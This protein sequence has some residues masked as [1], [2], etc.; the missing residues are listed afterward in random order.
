MD[1]LFYIDSSR[2]LAISYQDFFLSV[3]SETKKFNPHCHESNFEDV[4]RQIVVSLK[5]DIPITVFDCNLSKSEVENLMSSEE[6]LNCDK[7]IS[8]EEIN[9]NT[10]TNFYTHCCNLK[11]WSINL[12]TSGTTAKPRKVSHSF[13]SLNR[14]LRINSNQSEKIWGSA[15]N[16]THIAGLQVFFQAFFNLNLLV[17]FFGLPNQV[18]YN[19]IS[20]HGITNISG[21]STF[22]K[23]LYS[24]DHFFNS[25]SRITF[26]GEKFDSLISKKLIKMFPNAKQLNIYASTECGSLFASKNDEFEISKLMKEF[27]RIENDE[28]LIHKSKL[29]YSSN[30]QVVNDWYRTGDIVEITSNNPLRFKFTSRKNEIIGIGGYQVNPIEV[31]EIICEFEGVTDAYVFAKPNSVLGK[32]LCCDIVS[33]VDISVKAIREF[34]STRLQPYKI[35]RIIKFKERLGK[36]RSGKKRRV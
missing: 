7:V 14:E 27:I 12:F 11:N 30:L 21:T 6:S 24:K 15:Y 26:G 31:E 16:P 25:V 4:F 1:R 20:L 34:L 23:L 8:S 5:L 3:N 32:I 9:S 10:I 35:P 28:I 22:Y 33:E 18:I 13:N 2:D 17:R 36:T 19:D 29:G